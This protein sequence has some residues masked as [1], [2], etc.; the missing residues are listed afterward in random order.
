M[1]IS[2]ERANLIESLINAKELELYIIIGYEL[3]K[4][5]IDKDSTLSDVPLSKIKESPRELI[6]KGGAIGGGAIIGGGVIIGAVKAACIGSLWHLFSKD[7][8]SKYKRKGRKWFKRSKNK[9]QKLVCTNEIIIKYILNGGEE[10]EIISCI[11]DCVLNA[12]SI[13][14]EKLAVATAIIV[15]KNGIKVFCKNYNK[16]SSTEI[17]EVKGYYRK[18]GKYIKGY[19]RKKKIQ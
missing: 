9:V 12:L 3:D 4:N 7:D 8:D 10:I 11:A 18:D 6:V 1:E 17:T 16:P 14:N 15:I 13:A 5:Q 19:T 2:H